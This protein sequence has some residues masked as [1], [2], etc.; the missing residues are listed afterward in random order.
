MVASGLSGRSLN[1]A[2]RSESLARPEELADVS[3]D[4]CCATIG[5]TKLEPGIK[6]LPH[7]T[8]TRRLFNFFIAHLKM[9]N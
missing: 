8:G 1:P 7:T 3:V 2:W 6:R 4:T 5:N 9:A